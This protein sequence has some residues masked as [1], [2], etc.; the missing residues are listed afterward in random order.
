M[1]KYILLTLLIGSTHG[2]MAI[3]V[4]NGHGNQSSNPI[5]GC[6]HLT[7][8]LT[9]PSSKGCHTKVKEPSLLYL[10][11]AKE[12]IVGWIPFPRIFV[13]SKLQTISSRIW[14]LVAVLIFYDDNHYTTSANTFW[15]GMHPTIIL[16][17]MDK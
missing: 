14:T 12:R 6:L 9:N 7:Y 17:V 10:P 2:V 11:I 4:G 3:I 13:L 1:N 16:P 15:K 5:W 8:V